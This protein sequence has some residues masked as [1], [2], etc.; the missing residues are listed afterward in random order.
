MIR[1]FHLSD[2][3]VGR[4]EERDGAVRSLLGRVAQEMA[5]DPG[6]LDT[7]PLE[8]LMLTGDIVQKP[9]RANYR[10]AARLL[11]GVCGLAHKLLLV[12][13]NHD[14][15][16]GLGNSYSDRYVTRFADLAMQLGSGESFAGKICHPIVLDDGAGTRALVVGL[17]SVLRTEGPLDWSCGEIGEEQRNVLLGLLSDAQHGGLRKIVYLHHIPHK[18]PEYPEFM[19]LKDW[20]RLMH[21]VAG[22]ADVLAFGHQGKPITDM[23]DECLSAPAEVAEREPFSFG[24]DYT[25]LCGVQHLLDAN[26]CV[27]GKFWYEIRMAGANLSVE[28]RSA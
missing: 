10:S 4:S 19:I 3:H 2:L 17:D 9:T 15:A 18:V 25:V 1:I 23:Q 13:G 14:F 22:R 5:S 16:K 7:P 21:V 28:K 26:D 20:E 6:A 24:S 11:D 27:G 8:C 12:P